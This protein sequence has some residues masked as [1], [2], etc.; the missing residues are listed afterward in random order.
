MENSEIREVFEQDSGKL[1]RQDCL[2]SMKQ[3]NEGEITLGFTSPPYLNA[4]NYDQHIDKLNDEADRWEREEISYQEYKKFLVERFE[5]LLRITES[6]GYNVVNIAPVSWNGDRVALPF[7][8][9]SWMEEIGWEFQED[10][11]WEK[12]V[13]KDRRSGVLMQHPY[14][15]YYYPSLVTEYIFVFQKPAENDSK[16]NIYH[17]RSQKEKEENEIDLSDYHGEQSK[18][19]WKIRPT[20][21]QETDHPCP[22][23]VELAD[24]VVKFYSY[25][26][27]KV[28][29]IFAG[30]GSC[31]VA[32]KQRGREYVGIETRQEYIEQSL[33]RL[34][35]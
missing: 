28:I 34:N 19:A 9:V 23:P 32:A 17:N 13:A 4:I 6:G 15:G 27:D 14:P 5:E 25:K 24:R 30:S 10:I 18:N 3:M 35:E 8:F 16:Q 26:G 11:V 12:P 1:I 2:E 33:E 22:F 29:D 7:H 31:L 21:P 20:A